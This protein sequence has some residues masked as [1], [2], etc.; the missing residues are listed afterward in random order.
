MVLLLGIGLG[1]RVMK[2]R[3]LSKG[4]VH[5]EV[6]QSDVFSIQIV[7][8]KF[9][10]LKK[11]AEYKILSPR[12]PAKNKW[13]KAKLKINDES[14]NVELK[15]H[16]HALDHY[17]GG[18]Y[19]FSVK[20]KD[21]N[22]TLPGK[23]YKLIKGKSFPPSVMITNK[24]AFEMGLIANDFKMVELIVN[25][26]AWGAYCFYEDIKKDYL[27][28]YF[29]HRESAILANNDDQTRKNYDHMIGHFSDFDQSHLHIKNQKSI[30]FQKALSRYK[31][32]N[33]FIESRQKDSL[34]SFIDVDYM[35]RFLAIALIYNDVHFLSGDNVKLV[36]NNKNGKFYPLFR[37]ET[38]GAVRPKEAYNLRGE[39]RR[40][41]YGLLDE[42]LWISK[43]QYR[44]R[45]GQLFFKECLRI[46]EVR[47]AR[48]KHLYRIISSKEEY[49]TWLD[50]VHNES[51]AVMEKYEE[52][53][54]RYEW[55][56]AN[57]KKNIKNQLKEI[58]KYL[59]YS[60][61][62]STEYTKSDRYEILIDAF[63]PHKVFY[64][65]SLIGVF[66]SLN[67]TPLFDA[68]FKSFILRLKN[69]N[70]DNFTFVNEIT[71][72]TIRTIELNKMLE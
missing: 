38:A 59:N 14:I 9:E 69:R 40:L 16:G 13:V 41:T 1:V 30:F 18:M 44:E 7:E 25:G 28:R 19:S 35:G 61:V 3:L 48:N 47:H 63:V 43:E 8:K 67:Y 15:L 62:F 5:S 56:H 36:F 33:S 54:Y 53:P 55:L 70:V 52:V 24:W 21:N 71:N 60:K 32:L 27:E 11:I 4:K 64:K 39:K 72:D 65:D 66:N 34:L 31:E 26:E 6:S 50:S 20:M 12:K 2:S 37:I 51:K 49:F 46:N 68:R 57:Q 22:S 23:R 10:K 58:E 45:R 17:S 29:G 42:W